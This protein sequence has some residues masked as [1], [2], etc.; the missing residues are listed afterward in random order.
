MK[1]VTKH[2]KTHQ[3]RIWIPWLSLPQKMR[4][5]HY[6]TAEVII[7]RG[8]RYRDILK[9]EN[10]RRFLLIVPNPL[11]RSSYKDCRAVVHIHYSLTNTSSCGARL[12]SAA[13]GY[14]V[15]NFFQLKHVLSTLIGNDV[16]CILI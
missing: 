8:P 1:L 9:M 12:Q 7:L 16:V 15:Q 5:P 13:D 10:A 4:K 2:L 11:L 3:S 6:G 14:E